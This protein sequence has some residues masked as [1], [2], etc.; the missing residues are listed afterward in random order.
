MFEQPQKP[1]TTDWL[2][3]SVTFKLI[4]IC[5]LALV[6]LIPSVFIQNLIS[7]RAVRQEEV[8]SK[9]SDTWSGSQQV[10]GPV[11]VIPYKKN[12]NYI[13][14]SRRQTV[15]QV[16]DYL[17]ILPD[18][19]NYKANVK[20]ELLHRGIFKVVVYNTDIKVSGNFSKTDIS[21]LGIAS[22]QLMLDKAI[23][24]FGVSDLKGLKNNPVIKAAG[25]SLNSEPSYSDQS[26]FENGLQARINLTNVTDNAFTFNYDL[27]LKGSQQLYFLHL[28]KVTDV[29]SAGN[30]ATPSFD[31]RYLP[32]DRKVDKNGFSAKWRMLYYNRP[33]PQQ[34]VGDSHLLDD[35]KKQADATFGIKLQLP[36]DEYQKTMRTSKYSLLIIL[37]SFISLFL[38]ELIGK[39]KVHAF[40]YILI[41]AAM[42][43]Y[44]TLLLSFSEQIGFNWAYL[45]ASGATICLISVF[46]ASLLK[47]KKAAALFALILSVFYTFIFV[48][49]QLEDLA[50]MVGSVALFI[51]IAI[52]MY[53]SRRIDWDKQ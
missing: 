1:K 36:V 13:D 14:T 49:I 52:L 41:G 39:Q 21:A 10:N 42:V 35:K 4:F 40:N 44:Y 48:I 3:E 29:Q 45:V 8:I 7:E 20:G 50:L 46:I 26:V 25:Q 31:G 22:D 19:L 15:R 34:W 18:G 28:G 2:K 5:V 32:D 43:I 24:T 37:L 27:Q 16:I 47:N 9:V 38:T 6:L 12:E 30:W 33:F 51:I 11:L 53:V 17:Y 23:I